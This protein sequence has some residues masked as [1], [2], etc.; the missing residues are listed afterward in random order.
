MEYAVLKSPWGATVTKI[1]AEAEQTVSLGQPVITIIKNGFFEIEFYVPDNKI[2]NFIIGQKV[3]VTLHGLN[4]DKQLKAVINEISPAA[5]KNTGAFRI[6]AEIINPTDFIKHGIAAKI[7]INSA[8]ISE[9]CCLV[10]SSAIYGKNGH[11]YVWVFSDGMISSKK[12]T[13]IK[14]KND[15]VKITGIRPDNFIVSSG[16]HKL[17]ENMHVTNFYIQQERGNK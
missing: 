1:F 14:Y 11:Q 3:N 9:K 17:Y 5:D 2:R 16:T 12:I 8:Q 7:T 15:R 6:C 4:A 13:V 10:P